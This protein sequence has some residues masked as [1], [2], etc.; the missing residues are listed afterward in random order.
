VE[1]LEVLVIQKVNKQLVAL[2][3]YILLYLYLCCDIYIYILIV[4]E[5][6]FDIVKIHIHQSM[7]I[8]I[9]LLMSSMSY[10]FTTQI[11]SVVY[12]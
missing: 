6:L 5:T 2:F 7:Y 4:S 10:E 11:I 9:Y 1:I 8:R 3:I 12:S